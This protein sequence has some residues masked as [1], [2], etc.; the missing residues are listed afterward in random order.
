M[1][2][3]KFSL[4]SRLSIVALGIVMVGIFSF[5]PAKQASA[6]WSDCDAV[7]WMCMWV[8]AYGNGNV[9]RYWQPTHWQCYT[10][11]GAWW[12]TVSS[13]WNRSQFNMEFHTGADCGGYDGNVFYV[14]SGNSIGDLAGTGRNDE[15]RSFYVY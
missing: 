15:V 5:M 10:L 9:I 11:P 14:T 8:D 7:G 6:A 1:K 3:K 13:I 12:D 2:V 4:G